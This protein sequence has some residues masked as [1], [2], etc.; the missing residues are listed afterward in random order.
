MVASRQC[1]ASTRL[2]TRTAPCY[3][4]IANQQCIDFKALL[5]G[6]GQFRPTGDRDRCKGAETVYKA[7]VPLDEEDGLTSNNSLLSFEPQNMANSSA[8]L[9]GK[10]ALITGASR[11]IGAA[12]AIQFANKGI[13]SVAVT[14]ASSPDA[15]EVVLA[16][17]RELGVKKTVAVKA[18]LLDPQI[19]PNLI[20][21]VLTGLGTN[22]IDILVNNAAVVDFSIFQPFED[23]TLDAFSKQM[24]GNVYGMISVT[25]AVFPHL[26]PKG[27]RVINI[28]SIRSKTANTNPMMIYGAAKAA[29]DS[30]TK[31]LAL[32]YGIST[33]ATFNSV[34]VGGTMT[35][36]TKAAI[37]LIGP[38]VEEQN[39]S[40]V[41]T[42][43]RMGL[44]EDVAYVVGF[45]ASEEGRWINGANIAANG[46]NRD[47]LGLQG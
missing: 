31:S 19:G 43:K 3:G 44:P 41:T 2:D 30:V 23:I 29:V 8:S 34:S 7:T 25:R 11:G 39:I 46:G 9:A 12:I 22:T 24:N 37:E 20:P 33:G 42:E 14:Y 21:K 13:T 26:P 18:D 4:R 45:L 1:W 27:G 47:L 16:K 10:T 6:H 17:C 28:S 35:D 36:A 5:V 38:A 40:D 32:T 15:A